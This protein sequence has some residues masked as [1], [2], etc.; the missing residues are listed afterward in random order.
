MTIRDLLPE[1][2]VRY[3]RTLQAKRRY[4]DA[5]IR[6]G[7]IAPSAR[8]GAG[9]EIAYDVEL[10][11]MTAVG[12]YSYI[13]RGTIVGSG[14]IGKF[15][16][17]GYYCQI[18][19]HNH[20]IRFAST[21]PFTYGRRNIFGKACCWDDFGAP[22]VIGN[23]VWIG[24]GAQVTQGV[25]IGDGAV[26]AAGAVVNKPVPPY[27][28]VGGIPARILKKRFDDGRTD[29]LM[30]L[31]WWDAASDDLPKLA[32]LFGSPEWGVSAETSATG[33]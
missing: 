18:G 17:I 12:D 21:S 5:I 9:C 22:P 31:R 7:R 3:V 16:S 10:G 28:I 2:L 6:S 30:Q 27:V 33:R 14:T 1:P 26:V 25:T 8:I 24:S 15:C 20:P 32:S 11:S 19:M 23:D 4:P 29:A 13:N